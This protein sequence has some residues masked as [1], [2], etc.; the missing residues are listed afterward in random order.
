MGLPKKQISMNTIF[1]HIKD[2]LNAG[3]C[4]VLNDTKVLPA[5]LYGIKEETG[6]NV[7]V[8]LLTQLEGDHWETLV[9]PAKRVKKGTKIHLVMDY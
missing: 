1:K 2:Y 4:L 5:R 8:L 6:A 7:E 9:K 3:D